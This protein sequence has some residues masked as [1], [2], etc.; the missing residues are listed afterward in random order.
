MVTNTES[1]KSPVTL[2]N[3][4]SGARMQRRQKK[5]RSCALLAGN[6][7]CRQTIIGSTKLMLIKLTR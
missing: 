1:S 6:K 3:P 5:W 7:L 2:F 4:S